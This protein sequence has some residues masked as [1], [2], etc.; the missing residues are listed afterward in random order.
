MKKWLC[1][2]LLALLLVFIP[3]SCKGN[4]DVT[5]LSYNVP[6]SD[7]LI[8]KDSVTKVF[9]ITSDPYDIDVYVVIT[10]D[11]NKAVAFSRYTLDDY[12]ISY[13]DFEY[14]LGLTMSRNGYPIVMWLPKSPASYE[15][16]GVAN[17]E[18]THVLGMVMMSAGI[19]FTKQTQEAYAYEMSHLSKQFYHG[20]W[21]DLK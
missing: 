6:S 9:K 20:A 1:T 15:D 18:L 4:N 14:R 13:E 12:S 10:S 7:S 21:D 11:I 19:P 5:R 16:I 17:H 8:Y 3:F 2:A